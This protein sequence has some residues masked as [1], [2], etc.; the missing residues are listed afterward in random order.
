MD[1]RYLVQQLVARLR[2][3]AENARREAEAA[4]M[5]AREGA[6]PAE[7]SVDAR[8][9]IEYASLARGQARREGRARDELAA[10]EAFR[11]LALAPSAP[12]AVGAVVEVEDD[13]EGRTF[14]LAPAGAGVELTMP[15]GDGY[16]TV[17]TPASPL[18]RAVL[19]RKVGDSIEVTVEG[20]PR[21]WRVTYVA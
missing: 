11:P 6:S 7:R 16:L 2:A 20:E 19:G 13:G 12:I 4:A 9:A 18:G 15:G 8:V 17:V 1:K 14:F 21:E 5:E 3:S 10:L